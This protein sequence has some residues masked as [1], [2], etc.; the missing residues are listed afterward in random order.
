MSSLLTPRN[1]ILSGLTA[2]VVGCG[3][4]HY[5]LQKD[6][7]FRDLVFILEADEVET[8]RSWSYTFKKECLLLSLDEDGNTPIHKA[9]MSGSV[10]CVKHILSLL[11]DPLLKNSWECN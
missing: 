2:S 9:A 4:Y 3:Y 1:L 10:E 6:N 7:F 5:K 8:L 11:D